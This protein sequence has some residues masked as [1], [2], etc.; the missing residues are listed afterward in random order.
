MGVFNKTT[1]QEEFITAVK[2][3]KNVLCNANA[4]CGK[5]QPLTSL[6]MTPDRGF[7]PM[8]KIAIGD[9]VCSPYGKYNTV[10][11]IFPQGVKKVYKV[12]FNDYTVVECG[13]EHLWY[14]RE[15][16]R[17][18][19]EVVSLKDMISSNKT[20]YVPLPDVKFDGVSF[21]ER[22]DELYDMISYNGGN[23]AYFCCDKDYIAEDTLT[24]IRSIGGLAY[25]KK[26]VNGKYIVNFDLIGEKYITKIEET[27][28]MVLQQCISLDG[29]HLYITDGF[30]TTHNTSTIFESMVADKEKTFLLLAFN[31]HLIKEYNAKI[32]EYGISDRVTTSTLHTLA[33]RSTIDLPSIVVNNVKYTLGKKFTLV[34]YF[35]SSD[36]QA[37]TGVNG[38]KVSKDL[39]EFCSGNK[40]FNEVGNYI[41]RV[42]DYALKKSKMTHAMYMKLFSLK[43]KQGEI[44]LK[45][46]CLVIDEYQ[47]ME[48]SVAL[49]IK[50]VN[51]KQ[52][53]LVGDPNQA[54]YEFI[55]K[56]YKFHKEEF[57]KTYEVLYLSKSF[58]CSTRIANM[59][60]K[61]ILQPYL[62][63]EKDFTG[64]DS[65]VSDGKFYFIGRTNN[66]VLKIAYLL[67]KSGQKYRLT[68]DLK[69]LTATLVSLYIV[70]SNSA[71]ISK[72]SANSLSK[73]LPP[74][75]D[76]EVV[77]DV[78]MYLNEESRDMQLIPYLK[79]YS[80]SNVQSGFALMSYLNTKEVNSKDFLEKIREGIDDSSLNTV[81]TVFKLKGSEADTVKLY[82]FKSPR[83]LQ[84]EFMGMCVEKYEE[85]PTERFEYYED[86]YMDTPEYAR[87]I[88]EIMILYVALT[89]ARHKISFASCDEVSYWRE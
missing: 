85:D 57:L 70:V 64:T 13:L 65:D 88:A 16:Y 44:E 66:E 63:I 28:E 3:G 6:V 42:F 48:E 23:K 50:T 5:E 1:E 78:K 54:I 45:Q 67:A 71:V 46:D 43:C 18:E 34:G 61:N 7:I 69:Q 26:D 58:R 84:G 10:I 12:H 49:V 40:D 35:H 86:L 80:S 62:N 56:G 22:T 83:E 15:K 82:K 81:S 21:R 29:D 17:S 25:I 27:D 55:L 73:I 9:R 52:K 39:A 19:F 38:W 59:V 72:A 87:Y 31:S 76:S 24:L 2:S 37:I 32:K 47:D 33:K 74:Y 89:R 41:F 53:L 77:K 75:I 68:A 36:L 51:V 4:G 60:N 14:V 30:T 8:G 11:G 79:E 20:Y